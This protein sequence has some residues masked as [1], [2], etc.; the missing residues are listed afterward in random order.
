ME[1]LTILMVGDVVGKPGMIAVK[2]QLPKLVAEHKVDFVVANGENTAGG[3]GITPDLARELLHLGVDCITTGNHIWRQREIREYI[4]REKR[5]LRPYNFGE[6]QPG[7][8]F[9]RFETPGGVAIGVINLAGR[10]FMDPADNPFKA[11]DRALK[12][13]SDTQFC[14]VDFHA[15]ASSEK[16]AM[17]MYLAGRVAAV[18][19]TH[20]HVQTADNGILEPGTAYITDLGMTGPHDSVIGM[21]KDLV[22]DRFVNGMP[23]SFQ[24]AKHNI[25]FQGALIRVRR[26][27]GVAEEIQRI[28][29][30]VA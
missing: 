17:G 21:R 26:D 8:G 27:T 30:A 16:R 5:L 25:R 3:I 12:T 28:D 10:V 7:F 13:L 2:K 23:H 18:V 20:T 1:F 24:P 9:G 19:G 6:N 14:L 4:E 29:V 11:A 22:L 15:E